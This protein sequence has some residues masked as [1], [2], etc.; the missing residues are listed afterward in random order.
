MTNKQ[1]KEFLLQY[2]HIKRAI[3]SIEDE[4]SELRSSEMGKAISY[5]GLPHGTNI[6][7]LSDYAARLDCLERRYYKKQLQRLRILDRTE[8]AISAMPT[9]Q[10]QTILREKYINLKT[11]ERIAEDFG[12]DVRWIYVLHGRALD[13]FKLL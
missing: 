12:K 1:K 9:E 7:D 2:K 4:I 13:E 6:K 10:Y 5:D 3:R 8:R 11:W